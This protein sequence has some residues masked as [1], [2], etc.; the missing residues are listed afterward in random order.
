[1]CNGCTSYDSLIY[2]CTQTI[3]GCIHCLKIHLKGRH[4]LKLHLCIIEKS[5]GENNN[6]DC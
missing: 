1:M 5:Q 2:E 4:Y 3:W 6:L